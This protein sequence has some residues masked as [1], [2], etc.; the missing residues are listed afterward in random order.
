MKPGFT[1]IALLLRATI[2]LSL[3]VGCQKDTDE[4]TQVVTEPSAPEVVTDPTEP[5]DDPVIGCSEPPPAELAEGHVLVCVTL[6]GVA[7]SGVLVMQAGAKL[8]QYTNDQGYGLIPVQGL[9]EQAHTVVAS[10]PEARILAVPV[11]PTYT[12]EILMIALSRFSKADNSRFTFQDPGAPGESPST[13]QCGHCHLSQ[14]EDWYSS[15][16]RTSASNQWVQQLYSGTSDA[17]DSQQTCEQAGGRWLMGSVPGT[18]LTAYR[19]YVGHGALPALNVNCGETTSCDTGATVFGGCADCHAPGINGVIGGRN[20]LEAKGIEFEDGVH[21]DTCH[22]AESV[23]LDSYQPGVAGRLKLLRP[24]EPSPSIALGEFMPLTFGPRHDVPNPRMGAVQ[25]A[26]FGNGELCAG[27]HEYEQPALVAG[28]TLNPSRWPEQRLPVHS[29]WSEW[30]QGPLGPEVTCLQCHMPPNP[31]VGNSADFQEYEFAIE[32]IPYGFLR[33]PGTVRKHSWVGPRT[34]DSR[35]LELAAAV[36]IEKQLEGGVLEAR[37]T[38]KHVGPGHALP[39]GEPMRS[40][41][42]TVGALCG[43]EEQAPIGGSVV[44]DFG[45]YEEVRVASL[46]PEMWPD[47]RPGDVLRVMR[48]TGSYHDYRGFGP[49][50]DGRFS[51]IEKG[52]PVEEWVG[53]VTVVAV[54]DSGALSLSDTLPAGDFVY[55]IRSPL[56]GG[57]IQAAGQPGFG[58]ARVMVGSDGERMVP[59]FLA[60]DIASDNRLLPFD[61][62]TSAHQFSVNCDEPVVQAVL[63]YRPIAFNVARGKRA[64]WRESIMLEVER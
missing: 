37:V 58:F 25:R 61:Q 38:V 51:T 34:T 2:A 35:M 4:G 54:S 57:A 8:P 24:S 21:C 10:H 29:T 32:G 39:T 9:S 16:H 28:A 14:N 63:R 64:Q 62:W 23:A 6:D 55:R 22:R 13:A 36:F 3:V 60:V 15:A 50:G 43:D 40:M 49:F 46:V 53:E 11:S 47:A 17:L 52:M 19:C 59:H 41:V 20:L 44:P 26:H 33:T 56:A 42:L 7:A 5:L 30:E 27:C 1:F 12:N 45:G 31:K 48:R 18:A